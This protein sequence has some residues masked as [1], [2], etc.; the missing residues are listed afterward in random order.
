MNLN[1][2][3]KELSV[4]IGGL[5]SPSKMPCYS[6]S[7]S[8]KKCI[9]G[10]K[11]KLV[12]GSTCHRCYANRGNYNWPV[13]KDCYENRLDKM[14]NDPDWIVNM[15]TIIT[16]TSNGFFRWF[17][18]GDVQSVQNL[19]DI[20]Q[21]C[22][23]TPETKHWLP[24]REYGFVNAFIK[25]GGII[26]SN[27]TLRLSAYKID[28]KPPTSLAKRLGVLTS[29]VTKTDVYNCVAPGQGSKCLDCRKCWDKKVKNISYKYH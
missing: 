25:S 11:L 6:Y 23:N 19:K 3:L 20:L 27:V 14:I 29:T 21:V 26:P 12:V 5:G 1:L 7:I 10:N 18:S 2:T 13:M 17:D 15:S 8:N 24:T 22:A 9:T 4:L 28:A 16:R